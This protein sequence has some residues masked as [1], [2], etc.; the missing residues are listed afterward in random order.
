[1]TGEPVD[2]SG[3]DAAPGHSAGLRGYLARPDGDGPWPGVVVIFEA[4]G[5]DDQMRGHVERLAGLGYLALMP[6]LYSDGGARRCLVSVFRAM[7]SGQGRPFAD[8]ETARRA[9]A[10]R[11]DCT[12]KVGVLGFCLGGGFAL[13]SATRGFA[14]AAVNYGRLPRDLDAALTGACPVVGSYGGRDPSLRGAAVK[15]AAGLQRAGVTHD[16]REYP[17]A[18]HSF[19]NTGPNGPALARVLM[20]RSSAGPNPE[21]AADAWSRIQ[22]FFAAHLHG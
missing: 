18:G 16:V 15:L 1:M 2:L 17:Q 10:A 22:A 19:L 6:D 8:I 3:P 20:S 4:F 13:L 11:P 14:A 7:S 9:L 12:G 5:L 21:A